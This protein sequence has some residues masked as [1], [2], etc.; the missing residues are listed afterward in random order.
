M[1]GNLLLLCGYVRVVRLL[2]VQLTVKCDSVH[3]SDINLNGV[4][5]LLPLVM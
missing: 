1:A 5:L 3:V 2:M 4:I